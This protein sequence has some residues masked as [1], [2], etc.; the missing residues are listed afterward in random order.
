M[1]Y[2]CN[3]SPRVLVLHCNFINVFQALN[4]LK[5]TVNLRVMVQQHK[6]MTNFR[7]IS[8]NVNL[9]KVKKTSINIKVNKH[10]YIMVTNKCIM[11]VMTQMISNNL[12]QILTLEIH[13]I[14]W[15]T[16]KLLNILPKLKTVFFLN[17]KKTQKVG[18]N[19]NFYAPE[20]WSKKKEI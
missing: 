9:K 2:W 18:I 14:L 4:R 19:L 10:P 8:G 12:T 17:W 15:A 6:N 3:A 13:K 5:L 16:L 1:A 7:L 11:A 20:S